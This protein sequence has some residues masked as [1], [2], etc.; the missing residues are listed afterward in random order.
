MSIKRIFLSNIPVFIQRFRYFFHQKGVQEL[1]EDLESEKLVVNNKVS[2]KTH[3][4]FV[5]GLPKSGTT[6][7]EPLLQETPGTIQL[8]KSVLRVYPH[9]SRL[10]HPHDISSEMLACAPTD[11]LSFLKLHLNPYPV[12]FSVLDQ[13]KVKTVVLIRDLRDMLISRYYHVMSSD[14]HWD[15]G[16]LL[17][18]PDQDRLF[19]S[20][21][22]VSP[23]GA[24]SVIEYYASWISGWLERAN[25]KPED[26]IVIKY[27]S[28]RDDTLQTMR[29]V[30]DFYGYEIDDLKIQ[31]I[32]EKQKNSHRKDQ[33]RSLQSN[34]AQGGRSTSTFRKGA[35]GEWRDLFN[36]DE[37][38][39]IRDKA[40]EVLI[41]AG[42]ESGNHW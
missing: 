40:G 17:A 26:T 21:K 38:A 7:L 23:A 37:K 36:N 4:M 6:L 22:G 28:L 35:S 8:N 19:E 11:K 39:Y 41:K 10:G 32:I 12:N 27:E 5:A 15:Y 16:R 20:I 31:D 2:C 24:E 42:Y 30:Y 14:V 29:K 1:F 33:G 9:Y 18:M 34:L 25:T 13:H 3:L